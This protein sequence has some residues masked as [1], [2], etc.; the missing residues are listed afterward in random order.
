MDKTTHV[1]RRTWLRAPILI[2][3]AGAIVVTAIAMGCSDETNGSSSSSTSSTS[4]SPGSAA[5]TT[6][7]GGTGGEGTGGTGGGAGG[8]GGAGGGSAEATPVIIP[9]SGTGHDRFFGVAFDASGN[10]YATGV[11]ASSTDMSA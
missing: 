2:G 5:S 11:V 9:I 6:G 3:S 10:I 7:T 4:G 8:S 1:I